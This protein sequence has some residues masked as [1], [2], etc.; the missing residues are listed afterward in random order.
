M[1]TVAPPCRNRLAMALPAPFV[2]PVTRTR[3]PP[4]SLAWFAFVLDAV[5]AFSSLP[6]LCLRLLMGRLSGN[7]AIARAALGQ[8]SRHCFVALYW[9][10]A[11]SATFRRLRDR[12]RRLHGLVLRRAPVLTERHGAQTAS[13]TRR[14]LLS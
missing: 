6:G 11:A 5:M 14:P 2:P 10:D 1:T 7:Y 12:S 9:L 8:C 13:D 3:L 4:N